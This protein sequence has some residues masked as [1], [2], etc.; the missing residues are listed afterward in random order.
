MDLKIKI[1]ILS[2]VLIAAVFTLVIFLIYPLFKDIKNNSLAILEQKQKLLMLEAKAGNMEKFK[3]RYAQIEPDFKKTETL[4]V[5]A[6]L[7][8]DFIRFLEKTAKD[9][10]IKAKISLSQGRQAEG[11]SWQILPFQISVSG[12]FP[13][14]LRF[15]ERLQSNQY[16]IDV[17]D[18]SV[19]KTESVVSAGISFFVLAK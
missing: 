16:L 15:L 6:G 13:D 7:P 3:T 4:F 12:S 2:A 19:S 14:F 17:Q 11:K 1:R 5:N 10:N 18:L 9:S 8:V